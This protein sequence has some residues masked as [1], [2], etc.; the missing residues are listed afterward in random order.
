MRRCDKFSNN[1]IWLFASTTM[2][3]SVPTGMRV[4]KPK[5]VKIV[6]K[7]VKQRKMRD[8][9]QATHTLA[10]KK[11][12]R[13]TRADWSLNLSTN[14]WVT[15]ALGF[16]HFRMRCVSAPGEDALRFTRACASWGVEAD[17]SFLSRE[18]DAT[19]QAPTANKK[20]T[21]HMRKSRPALRGLAGP[22]L[23][24]QGEG[25]ARAAEAVEAALR[26]AVV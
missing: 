20:V 12:Q 7:T 8:C 9:T 24:P 2:M 13:M 19:L 18:A 10:D 4:H 26:L 21:R 16:H 6:V 3:V 15:R 22:R 5:K 25:G 17:E 1:A 23:G 11:L 14:S